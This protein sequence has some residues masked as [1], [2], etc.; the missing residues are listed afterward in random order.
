MYCCNN[1]LVYTDPS[2]YYSLEHIIDLLLNSEY[3]GTW[4]SQRGL[5]LLVDISSVPDIQDDDDEFVIM[6]LIDHPVI[7]LSDAPTATSLQF[8]RSRRPGIAG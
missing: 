3:G 4:T 6:N 5:L 7:S 8:F 2:G 1:P